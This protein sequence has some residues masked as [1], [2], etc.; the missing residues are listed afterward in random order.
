MAL[1]WEIVRSDGR[2]GMDI[3][4]MLIGAAVAAAFVGAYA[5]WQ[6]VGPLSAIVWTVTAFALTFGLVFAVVWL[7]YAGPLSF[8]F[9]AM[10]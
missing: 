5:R 1:A 8:D 10:D 9:S 6:A 2:G 3:G 4:V 7:F